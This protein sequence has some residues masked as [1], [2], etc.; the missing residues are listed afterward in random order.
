M[1]WHGENQPRM[2]EDLPTR[3][4]YRPGIASKL[5]ESTQ[6]FSLWHVKKGLSG[7][8]FWS[9]N[10]QEKRHLGY[11]HVPIIHRHSPSL[12]ITYHP[13]S[14]IICTS[15]V[16]NSPIYPSAQ[17]HKGYLSPLASIS[18]RDRS[19]YDLRND[20]TLRG[21]WSRLMFQTWYKSNDHSNKHKW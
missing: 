11:H 6:S 17:G 13:F 1:S 9:S 2:T 5:V 14:N 19:A 21:L 15:G 12:T 18:L 7:L 8:S 20:V 4:H 3:M 16:I 10:Q